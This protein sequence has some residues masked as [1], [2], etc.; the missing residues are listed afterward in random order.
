[1]MGGAEYGA[2]HRACL[3][4]R[5]L[6]Y[7]QPQ[8]GQNGKGD[9]RGCRASRII[10]ILNIDGKIAGSVFALNKADKPSGGVLSLCRQSAS[11]A[12]EG[13]LFLDGKTEGILYSLSVFRRKGKDS[14]M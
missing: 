2:G 1:M 6:R 11:F 8:M 9:F 3:L 14:V 7:P 10:L 12:V 5:G 13:A 4:R